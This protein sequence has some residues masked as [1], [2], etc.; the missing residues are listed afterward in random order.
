MAAPEPNVAEL[1][2]EFQA[3]S[4]VTNNW[5]ALTTN[6]DTRFC[7]WPGQHPDGRKHQE[8]LLGEE[9]FP[10]DKA[11]DVRIPLA[12]EIINEIVAVEVVAFFRAILRAG[13]VEAGD[14]QASAY[15]TKLLKWLMGTKQ[16]KQLVREVEL[17]SQYT[18]TY[19]WS[20][21]HITWQQEHLL[22]L[23]KTTMAGLQEIAQ[24]AAQQGNATLAALPVL[25]MDPDR[26]SDVVALLTGL[27]P[28]LTK[29]RAGKAIRD[30]RNTGV[31]QVPMPYL[32]TNEPCIVALKPWEEIVL[33]NDCA[34]IQKARVVFVKQWVSEVDLKAHI[35]TDGWNEEWVDQACKQKGV[36]STW[37]TMTA[38][39]SGSTSQFVSGP[40]LQPTSQKS[41]EII[42]AYVRQLD[43]D[44]VP[45][46]YHTIF[47][48]AVT[49]GKD[50]KELYAKHEL[51][52]YAHGKM[53]FVVRKR[54]NWCR[55]ITSSR[56][57]PEIVSTW[58]RQIK[59]QEDALADNTSWSVLPPILVPVLMGSNY[60]FG[61][62]R[63]V[64]IDAP[65]RE[66]RFMD[67]TTRGTPVAFELLAVIEKRVD[68]YF[69]RLSEDVP[70]ARA[71][72]KQQMTVQ[73]NLLC[74]TEAF[75]QEFQL[76]QQYMPAEEV[77]RVIGAP[78]PWANDPESIAKSYDFILTF[79]VR[80]LDTDYM[81]A[82]LT[83]IKDTIVP[84]DV[85]G[86]IDRS[87]LIELLLN[88]I[89]PALAN[90]L[91]MDGGQA[92]KQLR[93][94]VKLDLAQMFLG[95]E[96]DYVEMDPTA[97]QQLQFGQELV[98]NNPNYMEGL[99]KNQRFGELIQ[100]WEKN[101]QQSVTQE[102]NKQVGR[103]G[104]KPLAAAGA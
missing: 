74:W 33:P 6:E 30:L 41:I 97:S 12:D 21:L 103:I 50:G 9:V 89:D 58:Q 66:P 57:V 34:D 56:G 35:Y 4:P 94:K 52:G 32:C 25:I 61:P 96:A 100:N 49:K 38:A 14:L 28:H 51:L 87:K 67:V 27:I 36:Y 26:D 77:E 59:V 29:K 95:N 72:V 42:H 86:R 46:I 70:P 69:G 98:Q 53:P 84:M 63:K 16:Y 7:R 85:A 44:F 76:V 1:I 48:Q 47:H 18:H 39:Q 13:A 2:E 55:T 40:Q 83:A 91:I 5:N 20:V 64:E 19:G 99:K 24:Q 31:A 79:D 22:R 54:E 68:N 80:E 88:S 75:G 23:V 45:G 90:L 8:L 104:V 17:H 92:S 71:Q 3:C 62:A 81:Q 82:K 73:S 101:L 78:P 11:S 10:W 37:N 60:V 65:G 102:Q 15:A 43:E 93:D